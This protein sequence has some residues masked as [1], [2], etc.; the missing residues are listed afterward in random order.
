MSRPDKIIVIQYLRGIAATLVVVYHVMTMGAVQDRFAYPI[1]ECGVDIFFVISGFVMW[2]AAGDRGVVS[3]WSA[4]VWRI[5]PLCWLITSVYLAGALAVPKAMIYVH[6]FSV[7]YLLK[8]YLFIPVIDPVRGGILPV[9][10]VLWTLDYEMFF[11]FVF[12]LTLLIQPKSIRFACLAASL[13]LLVIVGTELTPAQPVLFYYTRSFL[14]EFL[15]GVFVGAL[16]PGLLS[17][18]WLGGFLFVFAVAVLV[19]VQ[20]LPDTEQRWWLTACGAACLVAGSL[21]L[22]AAAARRPLALLHLIGDASY[23]MYLVHPLFQRAIYL[24]I[25]VVLGGTQGPTRLAIYMVTSA[26]AGTLGGIATYYVIE[27]PILNLRKILTA[28]PVPQQASV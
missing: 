18:R 23:S 22:E 20:F 7:T 11:Y 10:A 15:A 21:S 26:V 4:R 13:V 19:V 2:T 16:A 14:L 3:F 9:Y 28:R 27:R 17:A 8:S 5:V 12:G 24:A 1:G 6:D 25:L